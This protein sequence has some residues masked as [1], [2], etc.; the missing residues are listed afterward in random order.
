[1]WTGDQAW[2]LRE[3]LLEK[4][5]KEPASLGW[6]GSI[7][8]QGRN[9]QSLSQF[10]RELW[11]CP[12][13]VEGKSSA[14]LKCDPQIIWSPFIKGWGLCPL[15][16][17]RILWRPRERNMQGYA[18]SGSLSSA[19]PAQIPGSCWRCYHGRGS[20]SLL[21]PT[22]WS[23]TSSLG[24]SH[25]RISG[26]MKQLLLALLSV[27]WFISQ[28]GQLEQ[29]TW[30]VSTNEVRDA[31]K[32]DG[33]ITCSRLYLTWGPNGRLWSLSIEMWEF[34]GRFWYGR[35]KSRFV[36]CKIIET[37]EN[38][39]KQYGLGLKS[40]II[41][42]SGWEMMMSWV[43]KTVVYLSLSEKSRKTTEDKITLCRPWL[44]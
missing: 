25:H 17:S 20:S 21:S 22:H 12:W 30:V 29:I 14:T 38:V 40:E 44:G 4:T 18:P 36:F 2:S 7:W 32:W 16:M 33:K 5:K 42:V 35:K 26:L 8:L 11:W 3:R 23:Q 6:R 1:M 19:T 28:Q 10:W 24:S 27:E 31:V 43:N 39:W 9:G 34:T 37:S 13:G 15:K 41:W